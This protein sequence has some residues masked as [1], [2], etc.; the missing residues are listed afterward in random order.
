[1]VR[2]ALEALVVGVAAFICGMMVHVLFG[3]HSEHQH[4]PKMKK[5][6][7]NLAITLFF[8]GFFLHLIFEGMG[9][10]RSYCVAKVK[11]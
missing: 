6:M 8:T 9:W 3:F 2:L 5:E 11:H 7:F 1:M 10:N 4:S